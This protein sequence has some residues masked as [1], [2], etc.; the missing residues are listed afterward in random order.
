[1]RIV[2]IIIFAVLW[3]G[4][5]VAAEPAALSVEQRESLDATL[6]EI[7]K[8]TGIP[9]LAIGIVEGGLP[10]YLRGFGVRD[11][12]TG[13]PVT[14]DTQFHIAS[15]S[16]TFTATA[17]M[18]LVEQGKLALADPVERV[19]PAFTGSGITVERLLTHSAG[20]SDRVR[21]SGATR[22]GQ[23]AEYVIRVARHPPA[24]LPG[25]GWKYSDADFNVL[26]A[27]VEGISGEQ[28]PDYIERHVFAVTGMT[29]S[30]ARPPDTTANIAW[31]H[32][33]E[34]SVRR[35]SSHPWDRVFVPSSGIQS[36]ANDLARWAAANLDRDAALLSPASYA[37]LFERRVDT[38]WPGVAMGLGWQLEQRGETWLPR[39]PGSEA[40]FKSLLTLFPEKRRAIVILSNGETTPRWEIRDAIEA[41]LGP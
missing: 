12:R 26:G 14:A 21:P 19:L 10:V 16:K 13:A 2:A 32:R 22:D 30:T 6:E 36:S 33:G 17:V 39:H 41:V 24:Y 35:S 20:L 23:V 27:V 3:I 8:R 11:I 34:K 5:V 31:P 37:A 40:G 15:I 29:Q 1:M 18:Q 9:G 25:K 7:R 38:E 28:F 4:R